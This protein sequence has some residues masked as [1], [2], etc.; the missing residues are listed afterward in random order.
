M[1]KYIKNLYIR[2]Y[3]RFEVFNIEFQ[4]GLNILIG[5]N[6]VGKS[7]VLEAI[8]I[9]LNQYYFGGLNSEDQQKL[10]MK[11]VNTFFKKEKPLIKDLPEI[12]IEMELALDENIKNQAFYGLNYDL[13]PGNQKR[14]DKYGIKFKFSFDETYD[15][16]FYKIDFSNKLNKVIPIEYY[17][18]VWTTFSGQ[19]YKRF[20][21]PLKSI[22]IDSSASRRDIYGNYARNLYKN[23]V[24]EEDQMKLSYNFSKSLKKT[25]SEN[26]DIL[27]MGEKR[28]FALDEQKSKLS[29]L[30]EIQENNISLSNMGKGEENIIKTSLSLNNK[31]ELDLVMLEE[32]ENHL[33]YSNTRMQID[34]IQQKEENV[35]QI[36]AT[37]HESMIINQLNLLKAIWIKETKGQS[38]KDLP[39]EDALYFEKADNFDILRYV[40]GNRIILVEGASEY[41][42]LPA[43]IK[44]ALDKNLDKN[45]ISI[46]S[47]RG[48]HYTHFESL[49]EIVNK[50]TLVLTDNDGDK[51]RVQNTGH[52]NKAHIKDEVFK[53]N[54]PKDVD[55]FTFEVTL[56]HNNKELCEQIIREITK[57]E[58][59]NTTY[60]QHENLPIALAAML[61]RKTEFSLKLA[62]KIKEGVPFETPQYIEEG[63]KWLVPSN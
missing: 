41:I 61:A 24:S 45:K 54:M 40:L 25:L 56:Y 46:I 50:K 57:G 60:K 31:S 12:E 58:L 55:E 48:I 37:T 26:K 6:S 3:K 20:M 49:S 43:I 8:N 62:E 4:K 17:H 1:E 14:D 16:E 9:V 30:I 32:P 44:Y 38:L 13:I 2:G 35:S 34:K 5:E 15:N 22:L 28:A 10:N 19:K 7:T 53:V 59:R 23:I 39:I 27:D 63:I 18:A 47:M 11:N 33:S 21:N 52:I 42:L 29:N 51:S 36:I